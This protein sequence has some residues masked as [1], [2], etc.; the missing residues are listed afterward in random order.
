MTNGF[1]GSALGGAPPPH[2]APVDDGS[3]TRPA[4]GLLDAA[5]AGE[6]RG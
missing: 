3:G 1:R 2:L 4:M 6:G 5:K